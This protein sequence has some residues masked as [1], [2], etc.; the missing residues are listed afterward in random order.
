MYLCDACDERVHS[1]NAIARMHH[2]QPLEGKPQDADSRRASEEVEDGAAGVRAATTSIGDGDA[3]AVDGTMDGVTTDDIIGMCDGYLDDDFMPS[4]SFPLDTLDERF[5]NDSL[6]TVLETEMLD[7]DSFLCDPYAA[8]EAQTANDGRAPPP[9]SASAP[10]ASNDSSD[11]RSNS[12]GMSASEISA[13]RRV[14]RDD[15]KSSLLGPIAD[16]SALDYVERNGSQSV[17]DVERSKAQPVDFH[18]LAGKLDA[19]AVSG[20]AA[21]SGTDVED[22]HAR[23]E[24]LMKRF[25]ESNPGPSGANAPPPAPTTYSGM[26]QPQT[27]LERLAR[28]KEK[29]KHRNFSKV[30]RYQS[31]KACADNRP[32]VKGKFV[33]IQSVPDLSAMRDSGTPV[34]SDE[35]DDA[36]NR[37]E[38]RDTIRELGLDRG[39]P[40]PPSLSRMKCGLVASASMPDFSAY[41]VDD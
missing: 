2:R 3:Y 14:G 32:R 25:N 5:W 37:E 6:R 10:T 4:S 30:I 33:R 24:Y 39:L 35:E 21:A 31:R 28:W 16:D 20:K 23:V 40:P 9:P 12:V 17:H 15:G 11:K 36:E 8:D 41:R 7:P 1:A 19:A 29:R 22:S 13:L 18:A 26:P 34:D 27:R 38:S